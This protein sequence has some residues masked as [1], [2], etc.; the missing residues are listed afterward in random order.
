MKRKPLISML[1]LAFSASLLL[2]GCGSNSDSSSAVKDAAVST[3]AGSEAVTEENTSDDTDAQESDA[4]ETAA[5]DTNTDESGTA[6][7]TDDTELDAAQSATDAGTDEPDTA[8]DSESD[9]TAEIDDSKQQELKIALSAKYPSLDPN[10]YPT[11]ISR[12]VIENLV[13][14]S[15]IDGEIVPGLAKDW[16]VSDD[17][18]VWEFELRDDVVFHDGT[19]MTSADVLYSAELAAQG[20]SSYSYVDTTFEAPSD[21]EFKITFPSYTNLTKYDVSIPIVNSA[22]H[23]ELGDTAYWE[24]AIGTGPYALESYDS[25]TGIAK[26][27]RN[28]NYWGEK[29]K[30]A[31][32]TFR[33]ISDVTS[34]L[35]ALEKGEVDFAQI[36]ASVYNSAQKSDKLDLTFSV[37]CL[38]CCLVFN[39]QE[40][41]TNDPRFRQAVNY[42]ID[43]NLVAQIGSIDGN[44]EIANSF[45]ASVWGEKPDGLTSY[46]YNPEKATQLLEEMGIQLP[47][48]LGTVSIL[49]NQKQMMEVV[50]QNLEAVGIKI[51][52]EML[53][54][55][56]QMTNLNSGNFRLGITPSLD[57]NVAPV[58][59]FYSY[60]Y[61][62]NSYSRCQDEHIDDLA[63]KVYLDVDQ[64][65]VRDSMNELMQIASDDALYGMLFLEGRAFAYTKG[66][67]VDMSDTRNRHFENYY[68][69]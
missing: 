39:T 32:I 20:P 23:K 47:C 61:S 17:G 63:E 37:P 25:A 13:E 30:I 2:G 53:D 12:L 35:I 65:V 67:H 18:R 4:D 31:N 33:V 11:D 52:L 58:W 28:E 46:E 6:A 43:R 27:V 50:K 14:M 21:Y 48:D 69:E 40:A 66:L 26:L 55:V 19:P 1:A 36:D 45:Y 7:D 38:A 3:E 49:S 51:E 44:Y 56:A 54:S 41:P 42:A 15:Y 29:G 22:K 57:V 59:T 24:Q 62:E 16:T 60:F 8:L 68:W 10:Y 9:A 5:A 34:V 64:T